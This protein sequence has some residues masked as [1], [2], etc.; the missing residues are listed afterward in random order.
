MRSPD[1]ERRVHPRLRLCYPI[2]VERD[3]D[4]GPCTLARTVTENVGARGA[5]FSTSSP[6]PYAVGQAVRVVVRVPH[7]MGSRANAADVML[8]MQGRGRVVRVDGPTARGVYGEDGIDLSGVA[9][10]FAG[11]LSFSYRWV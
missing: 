8:E 9:I 11:P 1:D 10:E 7:R 5:Y 6:G 4:A 2:R 3:A